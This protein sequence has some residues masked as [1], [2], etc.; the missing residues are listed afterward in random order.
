MENKFHKLSVNDELHAQRIGDYIMLVSV[1]NFC[2][3]LQ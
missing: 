1:H 3:V 2:L